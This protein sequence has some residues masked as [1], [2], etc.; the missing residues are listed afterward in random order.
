MI[1][2]FKY[3]PKQY[4]DAMLNEGKIRI[5]TI[6]GYREGE[7]KE[8]F[9][10]EE[11]IETR[12]FKQD[13]NEP[14]PDNF[15]DIVG[16]TFGQNLNPNFDDIPNGVFNDFIDNTYIEHIN[17]PNVFT[18]CVTTT[19]DE[20]VMKEFGKNDM[21]EFE[22][23]VCIKITDIKQFAFAI[24][25]YL[26]DEKLSIPRN[27]PFIGNCLYDIKEREFNYS[28]YYNENPKPNVYFLK[29]EHFKHQSEFRMIFHSIIEDDT[30]LPFTATIPEITRY[31][32]I[33]KF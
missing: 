5:G 23:M 28:K 13:F 9:D 12:V 7:N 3:T 8:I 20:N 31:L 1:G 32:K 21:G 16:H 2:Y 25:N 26:N 15:Y 19:A 4:A 24:D 17:Y 6:Y 14:L 10:K 11:G 27:K 33:H 22:E 29:D 30:I 18:Y